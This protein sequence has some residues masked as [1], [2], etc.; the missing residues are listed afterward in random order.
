VSPARGTLEHLK[1]VDTF[2]ML[3]VGERRKDLSGRTNS[4]E[5]PGSPE[6]KS[7]PTVVIVDDNINDL[8]LTE[9]VI[10]KFHRPFHTAGLT[11][12]QQAIDYLSG[13]GLYADR[14]KYPFPVLVIAD[15]NM[16]CISGLQL[17]IWI[18]NRFP[19]HVLPFFL[20]T[21]SED[22]EV[23]KRAQFLRVNCFIRK[24][25]LAEELPSALDGIAPA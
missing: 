6:T 8:I 15:L 22:P 23:L 7:R 14:K 4:A 16:P 25:N 19:Q 3:Q 9:R 10:R 20:Q 5:R 2:L 1:R 17:L 21:A 12:A 13:S 11:N 24:A 18:R